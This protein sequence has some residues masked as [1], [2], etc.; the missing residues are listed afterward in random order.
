MVERTYNETI[1]REVVKM[2]LKK[3]TA[4][5]LIFIMTVVIA[6]GCGKTDSSTKD[7]Q[8]TKDAE[9]TA[10]TETAESDTAADAAK[11]VKAEDITITFM[12][13]VV[14]EKAAAL[15]EAIKGFE[16]ETGYTVEFSAPGS[17][18]ENLMKVRIGSNELPDVFT[19]HGWSVARYGEYLTPVNSMSFFS[20]I[21]PQILP[22]ITA[23]SGDVYVLPIDVDI[24]GMVYNTEVL[25]AAGV[26]VEDI[27]TWEDFGK[28][29]EALKAKGYEAIHMGGK[30]SWPIGQFF[31]WVAPSFYVT[32]DSN[33]QR[34]ALKAGTFDAEVWKSIAGLMDSWNKA[35]YFN[36]DVLTADYNADMEAL[37]NG[38]AAFCFYGNYAVSDAKA[39]NANAK[40]GMMPIPSNSSS[41][42]PSLISGED[43]AVGIWKDTKYPQQAQQLLEYLARP[44]ITSAI[45]TAAGNKSG[46]TTAAS[47]IG[48]IQTYMDKYSTVETYPYFD[49]EYLPSGLWDVMCETGAEI[50]NGS[51]GSVDSA[52]DTI[53]N[54]FNDKFS[55]E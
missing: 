37:A 32:D 21:D 18:Y 16:A 10:G 13:N 45:A 31:D 1:K 22:A 46:L 51:E 54:T 5:I 28:A 38:E 27:R 44:E 35:G 50:L 30:D 11:D 49:R 39:V 43:I 52:A 4:L 42:E 55:A 41:D 53:L 24:A 25:D 34:D 29:C 9:A 12:T 6:A 17:D 7:N 14:G 19:T 48:D 23:S 3:I 33:N 26:K 40:I 2:R 36:K 15:E 47:N 8:E 20:S